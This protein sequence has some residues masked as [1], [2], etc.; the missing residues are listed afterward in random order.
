MVT[1][2]IL[3]STGSIGR[4]TLDV[5]RANPDL[6][7]VSFL[8]GSKNVELLERQALEFNVKNISFA[9][10][11]LQQNGDFYANTDIV[12]NGIGGIAGLKPTLAAIR[13]G[14]KRLATANKESLIAFSDIIKREVKKYGTEII[15]VDSEHSAV[16][17]LLQGEKAENIKKLIITASGGAFRDKTKE[18]LRSVTAKAAL[19]HPT[20]KMGEKVTVDSATLMN[21]AFEI[22]EASVLFETQNIDAV[23]ERQSLVHA[24]VE[25][26]DGSVKMHVSA[27]DMRL[28]IQYALTYPNACACLPPTDLRN[29]RFEEIDAE[30]FPCVRFGYEVKNDIKQGV[31]LVAADDVAVEKYKTGAIGFYGVY[32]LVKRALGEFDAPEFD[33]EDSLLEY[34]RFIKNK[35]D[36]EY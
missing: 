11:D 19:N 13:A 28:P 15:P 35:I 27:P 18:E 6:F 36:T 29:V 22:V 16:F 9:G 31:V 1:V 26:C 23:I 8:S 14:V 20:W 33:D 34:Y 3:G 32:D 30:R 12:V 25:L 7:S 24:M 21:K 4:Q 2:G 5:I 10:S 17:R